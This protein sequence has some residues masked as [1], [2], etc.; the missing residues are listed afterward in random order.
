MV[1]CTLGGVKISLRS[2]LLHLDAT[3]VPIL[4]GRSPGIVRA[5]PLRHERRW[6]DGE[7]LRRRGLLA[8]GLAFWNRAFIDA[9]DRVA[10]LPFQY[11]EVSG[12]VALDHDRQLHAIAAL[13]GEEGLGSGVV[14]PQIVMHELKTPGQFAG[15]GR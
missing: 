15:L 7:G 2:Q 8:F 3:S 14:I 5:Q 10:G 4:R 9:K 1:P 13:C 6:C 12:L 11:K